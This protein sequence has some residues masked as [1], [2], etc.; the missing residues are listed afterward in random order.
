MMDRVTFMCELEK[1]LSELPPEERS[2]ALSFFEEYFD[3][4]G[5]EGEAEVIERLGSPRQA[6]RRIIKDLEDD[7]ADGEYTEAGY[8]ETA[9]QEQYQ[10]PVKRQMPK[11]WKMDRRSTLVL[12]VIAAVFC[13][14]IITGIGGGMLGLGIGLLTFLATLVLGTSV[15]GA[16]LVI[17]GVGL[18]I[19]GSVKMAAYAGSG[20][21]IIGSGFFCMAAGMLLFILFTVVAFRL[22]PALWQYVRR[23]FKAMGGMV[24]RFRKKGERI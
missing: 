2:E 21:L 15:S 18:V 16:A 11:K 19:Y 3:T 12:V 6:A 13:S 1:L 20:L 22:L 5:P 23:F 24:K 8:T 9:D 17:T 10:R 4:A 7:G 14:P